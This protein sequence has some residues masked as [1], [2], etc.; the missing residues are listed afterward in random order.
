MDRD[1]VIAVVLVVG[2]V[3]LLM[4]LI[5]IVAVTG[6]ILM[7]SGEP[8][9]SGNATLSTPLIDDVAVPAGGAGAGSGG[10][11]ADV[12]DGA[13]DVTEPP[14]PVCGNNKK[15]TG[16]QCEKDGDCSTAQQ[17]NATCSCE[18]KPVV[19]T[20]LTSIEVTKLY[21]WCAPDFDGKKG[22]AIKYI[23]FKNMGASFSYDGKAT[24]TAVTGATTDSVETKAAF[25]F[26]IPT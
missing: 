11:G 14:A 12:N 5:G 18:N 10:T 19:K 1:K 16:E 22:L 7:F 24:I 13:D 25:K 21:F 4:A 20:R 2:F 8:T 17:C 9:N 23:E 3:F 15:E 6:F 26:T